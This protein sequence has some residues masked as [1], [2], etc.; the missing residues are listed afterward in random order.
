MRG[1]GRHGI[2]NYY[3]PFFPRMNWDNHYNCWIREYINIK[4]MSFKWTLDQSNPTFAVRII[5]LYEYTGMCSVVLCCSGV[6]VLVGRRSQGG[7]RAWWANQRTV[8]RQPISSRESVTWPRSAR[9]ISQE[10]VDGHWL[11]PF[12]ILYAVGQKKILYLS[13]VIIFFYWTKTIRN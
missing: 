1:C 11:N 2:Q 7:P 10:Q 9:G 6:S 5:I 13:L 4:K 3:C 8:S 12:I